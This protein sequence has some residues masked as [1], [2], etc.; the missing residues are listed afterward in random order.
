MAGIRGAGPHTIGR[1]RAVRGRRTVLSSGMY[2]VFGPKTP[3]WIPKPCVASCLPLTYLLTNRV[4]GTRFGTNASGLDDR[5]CRAGRPVR[6][7]M[8]WNRSELET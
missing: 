4:G 3:D 8:A 1:T 5:S 6:L 7:S 2:R